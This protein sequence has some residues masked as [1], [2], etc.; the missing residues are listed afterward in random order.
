MVALDHASKE[1]EGVRGLIV[2]LLTIFDVDNNRR[3]TKQEYA[4]AAG[5]LGFDVNEEAWASLC[6]RFG[7]KTSKAKKQVSDNTEEDLDL[8]LLGAFFANKYDSLLEEIVRRL[9]RGIISTNSRAQALEK[10]MHDVERLLDST[11]RREIRERE[12]RVNKTLRRWR[13][14]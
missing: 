4:Q 2:S 5:P 11:L 14:Q 7:D 12:H 6:Q 1:G 13:H 3:L 9:L 8:S 10:R